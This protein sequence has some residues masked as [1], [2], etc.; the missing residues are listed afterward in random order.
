MLADGIKVTELRQRLFELPRGLVSTWT[1]QRGKGKERTDQR[2]RTTEEAGEKGVCAGAGW[3]ADTLQ[4][5][6]AMSHGI[7]VVSEAGKQGFTLYLPGTVSANIFNDVNELLPRR[8]TKEPSPWLNCDFNPLRSYIAY[9]PMNSMTATLLL[10][11]SY[12]RTGI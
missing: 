12:G 7:Q 8:S 9:W 10:S 3:A 4:M 11:I 6:G 5:E 1:L 2:K